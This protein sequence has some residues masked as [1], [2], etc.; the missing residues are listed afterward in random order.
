MYRI[1]NV[2]CQNFHI[3]EIFEQVHKYINKT[4]KHSSTKKT[5][6]ARRQR[7]LTV[8]DMFIK[9]IYLKH[10]MGTPDDLVEEPIPKET[11]NA[12]KFAVSV[13]LFEFF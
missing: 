11:P 7:I 13:K 5:E 8:I 10:Y 6:Q 4:L 1:R 9:A 12:K 3:K 2:M